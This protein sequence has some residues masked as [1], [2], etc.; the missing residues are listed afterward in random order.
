MKGDTSIS[1]CKVL[2]ITP[3]TISQSQEDQWKAANGSAMGSGALFAL[4]PMAIQSIKKGG[5]KVG[6]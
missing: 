1:H 2:F 4:L 6:G 3:W 5:V